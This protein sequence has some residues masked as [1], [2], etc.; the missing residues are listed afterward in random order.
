MNHRVV[1]LLAFSL[2]L[3]ASGA[4]VC[5]NGDCDEVVLTACGT[6]GGECTFD[7]VPVLSGSVEEY[8]PT[9]TWPKTTLT[10]ALV[11]PWPG[12]DEQSQAQVIQMAFQAWAHHC[13]L[14]FSQVD[15]ANETAD[16]VILFES[17]DLGDGTYFDQ[18][19]DS[20]RNELG[21]A[22][23][24]GTTR[25]G[26]IQLDAN[27]SWSL[28]P[29]EGHKHLLTILLHEIGHVLGV[30]HVASPPPGVHPRPVMEAQNRMPVDCQG[31]EDCL[32]AADIEAIQ[33][34]YGSADGTVLPHPVPQPGQLPDNPG[35][36]TGTDELDSDRDGLPNAMEMLMLD[37]DPLAAD[38]DGDGVGDYEEVFIY[39][40]PASSPFFALRR[41]PPVAVAEAVIPAV[42]AG[43]VTTLNGL[44]SS[45]PC[46]RPLEYSWVQLDGVEVTLIRPNIAKPSFAAPMV[47]V[48]TILTF[49]LTVRNGIGT[50]SDSV[51]VMVYPRYG[52]AVTLLADAGENQDVVE[53]HLV[54]LDGSA[55][56]G[57]ENLELSYLWSPI[58]G[59]PVDL[60]GNADAKVHFTAPP[61][62]TQTTLT[63]HLEVSDGSDTD[64]DSV[65]ITVLPDTADRDG[66]GL[67]DQIE[68]D[69]YGTDAENPDSDGDGFPDGAD[70]YP[71][72]LLF[73]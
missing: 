22:F 14:F 35:D 59:P 70:A 56:A 69:F 49:E 17:G 15:P 23:F 73:H 37:T 57:S 47:E 36:W 45:D 1:A 16:I 39:G 20:Q 67:T 42:E 6:Y 19:S 54:T 34:L 43:W 32:T 50:A 26:L 52:T 30:E 63:F 28:E 7:L 12:L 25:A 48:N 40:T 2:L 4:D 65:V 11:K 51:S 8:Q 13:P 68:I 24:P 5:C 27:D 3:G 33:V 44:H 9:V 64:I 29:T 72:N 55:S 18:H 71:R 53:G 41:H 31:P 60:S 10:W 61:V 38:S 21:R 62:D 66:D 46:G 58:A